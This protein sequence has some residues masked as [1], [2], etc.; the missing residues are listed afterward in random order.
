MRDGSFASNARGKLTTN[1]VIPQNGDN[2]R[3]GGD[4]SSGGRNQAGDQHRD[5]DAVLYMSSFGHS[6]GTETSRRFDE[7]IGETRLASLYRG[8]TIARPYA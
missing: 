7:T 4:D 2:C 8:A 6:S 5:G 3:E 1:I